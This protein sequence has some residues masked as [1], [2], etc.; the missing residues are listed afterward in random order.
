MS[1]PHTLPTTSAE[2]PAPPCVPAAQPAEWFRTEVQ[3]HEPQLRAW[4]LRQF[5][6]LSDIDDVVQ[7][8]RLSVL[9]ARETGTIASV[10]SYFFT[11]ARNC[12]VA[13]FRKRK[14]LADVP[15]SEM[16]EL[17]VLT[18]DADVAETVN[19]RLEQ[20]LI[21]QAIAALPV[22]C[23]EI[24]ILRCLQGLPHGEI[25]RRLGLSEQTV[26]VQVTRGMVK[27]TAAFAALGVRKEHQR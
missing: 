15:V 7:E 1:P 11:T 22:R 24:V 14:H 17:S 25:A 23:R 6:G 20:E 8:A 18:G 9:K 12:A 26:R 2:M 4:L 19:A 3:P 13:F 10:K 27:L 5:P 21:A 16:P